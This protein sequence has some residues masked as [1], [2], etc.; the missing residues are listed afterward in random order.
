MTTNTRFAQLCK[1]IKEHLDSGRPVAVDMITHKPIMGP[2]GACRR[3]DAARSLPPAKVAPHADR[4]TS[5]AGSA[6][7]ADTGG[8]G[9]GDPEPDPERPRTSSVMKGGV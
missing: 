2:R 6:E 3:T 7:A 8:D 9:D 5:P 1:N 4:H